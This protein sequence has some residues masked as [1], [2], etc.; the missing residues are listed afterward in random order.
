MTGPPWGINPLA[1]NIASSY[2]RTLV[3][4]R[5]RSGATPVSD[6]FEAMGDKEAVKALVASKP[7]LGPFAA[8]F[9][10]QY[11]SAVRR[12][13]VST[14]AASSEESGPDSWFVVAVEAD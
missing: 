2:T 11:P 3:P 10:G 13:G 7:T 6:V 8:A 1:T 4:E 12:L 14:L 5:D 9:L